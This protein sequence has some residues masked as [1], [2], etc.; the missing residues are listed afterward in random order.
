MQRQKGFTLIEVLTAIA[1]LGILTGFLFEAYQRTSSGVRKGQARTTQMSNAIR[2]IESAGK[3][4]KR[5]AGEFPVNLTAQSAE[6]TTRH[7]MSMRK[8][9]IVSTDGKVTL[10]MSGANGSRTIE[11]EFNG[12]I[13]MR[14]WDGN[15]WFAEWN[16]RK[17]PPQAVSIK[18]LPVARRQITPEPFTLNIGIPAGLSGAETYQP[19]GGHDAVAKS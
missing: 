4:F 18:L 15:Q 19:E 2:F 11:S 14:F 6:F 16:N 10:S 5:L 9:R 8:T 1:I 3:E 12:S 17:A 13:D 7:G